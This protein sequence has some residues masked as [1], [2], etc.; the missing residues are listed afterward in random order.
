MSEGRVV[1]LDVRAHLDGQNE[2]GITLTET[3]GG[4]DF[5]VAVRPKGKRLVY[6]GMLSDVAL[7][8]AARHAKALAAANGINVPRARR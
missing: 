1:H 2:I 4:E 8:V 6:T 5:V 3:A 7:I